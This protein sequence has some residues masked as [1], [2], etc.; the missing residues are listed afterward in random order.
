MPVQR[1]LVVVGASAGGVEALSRLVAKL[2]GDLPATVLVV[3]H[4][5]ST[6]SSSLPRILDR[7]GPLPA[8]AARD[9][10][11]LA[12]GRILV[13]PAD[14]HLLVAEGR[15]RLARGPRENG[16]RP[17]VDPLFRSAARWYGPRVIGVVLSGNL[18]DGSAGLLA[19]R[20]RGG[21]TVVQDPQDAHYASMPRNAIAAVE[22][23]HVAP[24]D[25]LG[26]LLERLVLEP[27]AEEALPVAEAG[28]DLVTETGIAALD[29]D[30][31]HGDERPGRP[32]GLSCPDCA[33]A[34]WEVEEGELHRYRCRVG[35]AWS[36]SSLL[37][38]QDHDLEGALWAA[39]RSLEDRAAL[40]RRMA[41]SGRAQGR[42]LSA[43]RFE[44]Q[45][46][47]DEARATLVRDLLVS[48]DDR[49]I[50]RAA[51]T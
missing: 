50:A 27:L 39:L 13:A 14:R 30:A 43:V 24:V 41:A 47:E 33:G 12:P 3:L 28:E 11:P 19:I 31:L 16:H 8:T 51:E 38:Q 42:D 20:G 36:P 21:A 48:W 15:V 44:T 18:D 1:D 9:G 32:A 5:P 37:A 45:A 49:A 46:A 25:D 40:A 17:A 26:A 34:L 6:P 2:P 23:D 4:I 29:L 22:P 35:H 7:S 10:E